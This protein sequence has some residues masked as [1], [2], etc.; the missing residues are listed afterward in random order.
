MM[1]ETTQQNN[2]RSISELIIIIR[3]I[4]TTFIAGTITQPGARREGALQSTNREVNIAEQIGLVE[5]ETDRQRE[6]RDGNGERQTERQRH[7]ERVAWFKVYSL[8][9]NL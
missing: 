6:E 4:I 3:T 8:T 1:I 5:T 9:C 7:R 2:K